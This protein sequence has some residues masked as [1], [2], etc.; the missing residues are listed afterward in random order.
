MSTLK[1]QYLTKIKNSKGSQTEKLI[2]ELIYS[3]VLSYKDFLSLPSVLDLNKKNGVNKYYN[4]LDLFSNLIYYDYKKDSS[5]YIA[6]KEKALNNL[7]CVSIQ[8][9]AKQKKHI[10]FEEL[11]RALDIKTN[12][13]LEL[14]LF[15]AISNDLISGKVDTVK[16][17]VDINCVKARNNMTDTKNAEKMIKNWIENIS[18]AINFADEEEKKI[19]RE[20]KD[21]RKLLSIE[22]SK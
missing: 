16:K 8:E 17:Y 10:D 22:G 1:D 20:T 15:K 14:I 4:T 21:N 5:K 6:L 2:E 3:D 12:F 19:L 18:D 7:K 13:D 11:K 9:M